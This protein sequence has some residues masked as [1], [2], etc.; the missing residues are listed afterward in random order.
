MVYCE[1]YIKINKILKKIELLFDF[2]ISEIYNVFDF[3]SF[4]TKEMIKK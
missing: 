2:V 3:L 4:K 1:F